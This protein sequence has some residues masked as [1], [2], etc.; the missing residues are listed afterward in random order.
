MVYIRCA[1]VLAFVSLFA[2]ERVAVAQS[3]AKTISAQPSPDSPTAGIQEAI[4]GL[5]PQGGVIKLVAGEYLLRQS[6]RVVSNFTIEGAG[7]QT[8]LRKGK[9][10]GSKLVASAGDQ[11]RSL[12]VE[13]AEGLRVGDEIGVFDQKTVGWE[14]QHAIIKQINGN[15][16]LINRRIGRAFDPT[17]GAS[18]V[19]YFPA[20]SGL[21]VTNVIIR[22]I[23][24][25]GRGEE[26]PG[27]SVIA[28]RAERTP[29][30]LGFTFAAINLIEA[31]D[32]RVENCRVKE[33]P[34]DGIS[35]QRGTG[36]RVTNCV[37][38]R[39]RGEG[40]HPGG[41]LSDS[42]FS[43]CIARGNL[44]NGLFF[45]AGV[46][47][48]SVKRN[49]F[50]G[51]KGNGIGDLGHSGDKDN[52]V[53]DNWC[54]SNGKNGIALW[55]GGPNTVKHNTCLNNSQAEPGRYSGIWLAETSES[56]VSANRS[57]DNQATKT[58]KHGIEELTNCNRNTIT[59]NEAGASAAASLRLLGNG[60][61]HAD[62][63]N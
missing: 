57:F 19:N 35:L 15:E 39:C 53:E 7:E 9:Q 4:D 48:V 31:T 49:K 56:V 61:R 60:S 10:T 37:V 8:V 45:C 52:V 27:P 11:D 63:R 33:W 47:R 50:I 51:N 25:D 23:T 30:E 17:A 28:A 58:Q 2:L 18:V 32:S 21:K 62:N 3:A 59:N 46:Q 20:I 29:P 5:G 36:N 1:L 22:K 54:E 16:L 41:G 26:N 13:S 40:L 44:A 38:E 55:D 34:A 6:I 14:H 12:R 43:D 42:E 24:I